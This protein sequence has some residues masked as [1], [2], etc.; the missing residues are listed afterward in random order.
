MSQKYYASLATKISLKLLF[1]NFIPNW[2]EPVNKAIK[3]RFFVVVVD[4]RHQY[5][6]RPLYVDFDHSA[7]NA[8]RV[9]VGTEQNVVAMINSKNGDLCE[10]YFQSYLI[11]NS[12]FN[13]FIL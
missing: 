2:Q 5:V 8:K 7:S 6:G 11:N 1:F 13:A 4:R 9:V 3:C 10:Y 12:Q